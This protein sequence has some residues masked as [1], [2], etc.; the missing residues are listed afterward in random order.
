LFELLPMRA[1]PP[2]L[3]GTLAYWLIGFSSDINKFF[4]FLAVLLLVN[5]VATSICLA[6]STVVP[7]ISAGNLISVILMLFFLMFGGFLVSNVGVPPYVIWCRYLSFFNYALE[8]MA[9]NELTG[10][11]VIFTASG[12][13]DSTAL[14]GSELLRQFGFD[15]AH[16]IRDFMILLGFLVAYLLIGYLLLRFAVREK[17]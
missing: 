17:R 8:I 6:I 14:N 10:L 9:A 2:M 13:N 11:T 12:T 3:L 16:M 7:S 5:L 1:I 15:A 4:L